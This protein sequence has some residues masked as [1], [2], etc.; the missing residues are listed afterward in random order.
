MNIDE[1]LNAIKQQESFLIPESW[2]QGRTTFGGLTAAILAQAMEADVD[3]ARRLRNFEIGFVRPLESL[4]PFQIEIEQLASGRTVTIKTARIIQEGKV[5]ATARADYV[6]PLESTVHIDTFTPPQVQP[7]SE[8]LPFA[9]DDLPRFFNHFE[10]YLSTSGVPFSGQAVPELGGWVRFRETPAKINNAHLIC[11][12]DAWP[13][14]ASPHY[15]GFRPLSTISWSI[16]FAH[17]ATTLNA[18]DFLGYHA[19]LNF[20]EEGISSSNAEIWRP[21]GKLLATS[22]QTNIIY[23]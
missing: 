7:L 2:A 9:G 4:L 17:P 5:R 10:S 14:T 23:G 11:M 16:H 3:P 22:V 20:G 19:K 15:E 13:P 8:A 21:D 12:I 18:D 6:L 1:I